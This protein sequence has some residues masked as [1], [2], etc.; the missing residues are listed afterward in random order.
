MP[1]PQSLPG[2]PDDYTSQL[3][4][5]DCVCKPEEPSVRYRVLVSYLI[6]IGRAELMFS[7][8]GQ[9]RTTNCPLS[10]QARRS[11]RSTDL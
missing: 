5:G 3:F 8:A 1:P 11:I 4:L 10:Y 6:D 7:A 2:L 9:M